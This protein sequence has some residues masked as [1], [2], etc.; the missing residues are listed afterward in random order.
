M[1]GCESRRTAAG[2]RTMA[3]WRRAGAAPLLPAMAAVALAAA[4]LADS[5]AKPGIGPGAGAEVAPAGKASLA[6]DAELARLC[7]WMSGSFSSEAQAAADSSYFDIRL[8]MTPIWRERGDALWLYV[9]QAAAERRERPYRQRVYRLSRRDDGALISEVYLLPAPLRFAGAWREE[10]PLASL[11]PDSLVRREGCAIELRPR[12][13]GTFAGATSGRDCPSDL[14]GA[15]Y[16][17]SEAVIGP[18]GMISWDRGFDESGAQ[19]WGAAAGGY[20]FRKIEP[21]R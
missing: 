1:S 6:A 5:G 2:K 13:D 11:A 19:V 18:D 7:A 16:A 10:R 15:A 9:E 8:Q 14:R 12:Q 3:A 21:G 4:A 17:T 20:I